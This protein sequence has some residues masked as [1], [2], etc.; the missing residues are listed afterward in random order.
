MTIRVVIGLTLAT[1]LGAS[2]ALAAPVLVLGGEHGDFTRLVIAQVPQVNW[3]L[4]RVDGGYELRIT[5][6]RA[7]FDLSEAFRKITHDRVSDIS[8]PEAGGRLVLAVPE[9]VSATAT[10]LADGKIVI[11]LKK[12]PPSPQSPFERRLPDLASDTRTVAPAERSTEAVPLAYPGGTIPFVQE[13]DHQ[14]RFPI[15]WRDALQTHSDTA[16]SDPNTPHEVPPLPP[17]GSP[18]A[19]KDAGGTAA[20]QDREQGALAV[21]LELLRQLSRA[22]S[23]GLVA[24]PNPRDR[25]SLRHIPPPDHS[26]GTGAA[27][28][29]I[30]FRAETSVD[31]TSRNGAESKPMTAEGTHCPSSALTDMANWGQSDGEPLTLAAARVALIGEFDRPD[32]EAAMRLVRY[33]MAYGLGA[34]ARNAIHAFRLQAADLDLLSDIAALMDGQAPQSGTRLAG[35]AS[36][37]T[38]IAVW[39]ALA[40]RDGKIPADANFEAVLRGYSALPPT[41]RDLM[42]DPLSHRLIAAGRTAEA[43]AVRNAVARSEPGNGA[44][45]LLL[46]ARIDEASRRDR[47][48]EAGYRRLA[49][50]D[51]PLGVEAAQSALELQLEHGRGIDAALVDRI[52]TLAF[53]RRGG[54]DGQAFSSLEIRARGAMG[55]Y[56]EAFRRL[57]EARSAG[58]DV[59]L[60]VA[61]D[62][63]F[64]RAAADAPALVFLKAVYDSRIGSG[65]LGPVARIAVARRL[66]AEGFGRRAEAMLGDAADT[67][68]GRVIRA[69]AALQRFDPTLAKSVVA[70]LSGPDATRLRVQADSIATESGEPAPTAAPGRLSAAQSHSA[71]GEALLKLSGPNPSMATVSV[72]DLST[73]EGN[74]SV[75]KGAQ[76]LTDDIAALLAAANTPASEAQ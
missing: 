38:S 47:D 65:K 11:D 3:V 31:V 64:T 67:S 24:V 43:T 49:D 5:G 35:L 29:H 60:S 40:P 50:R 58:P 12:A 10:A 48:A 72:A 55:D 17:P 15:Y 6:S 28:N 8:A 4:G 16:A 51:D 41:L 23:Q 46:D 36:C 61:T 73:L 76:A 70:G 52:A 53:E 42:S 25:K 34:E 30:E 74:R 21:E 59:N 54:P 18:P 32:P 57:A 20:A 19:R 2:G 13:G 9:G 45:V 69:E 14:S 44:H 33:Y 39:A 27:E 26:P 22:A 68:E 1:L 71:F 7:P 66:I 75:V 37:D 63:L 62:E 56:V